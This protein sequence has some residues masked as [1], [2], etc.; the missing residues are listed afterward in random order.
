[1]IGRTNPINR[2]L[3][4]MEIHANR[5]DGIDNP[6]R[7]VSK[8]EQERIDVC[9]DHCPWPSQPIMCG[10]CQGRPERAKARLSN[11]PVI[12]V[13]EHT[14]RAMIMW[15]EWRARQPDNPNPERTR[16]ILKG[17]RG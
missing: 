2:I 11:T 1:M 5:F 15:L 13:Q 9:I 8:K 17:V 12:G 10:D 4:G 7:P 3:K 16:E 6:I 14:S